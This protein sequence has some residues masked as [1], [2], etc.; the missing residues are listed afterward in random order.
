MAQNQIIA[1]KQA[2]VAAWNEI[3]PTIESTGTP[4]ADGEAGRDLELVLRGA[5][6]V[7]CTGVG[8]GGEDAQVPAQ[9][10]GDLERPSRLVGQ[11]GEERAGVV[12]R[13]AALVAHVRG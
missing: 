5:L 6:P 2:L 1:V 10:A 7:G 4:V 8:G 12:P 11:G 13:P 3:L 9:R